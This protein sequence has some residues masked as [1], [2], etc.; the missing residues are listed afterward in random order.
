[1]QLESFENYLIQEFKN[2]N[3]AAVE[4]K[5]SHTEKNSFEKK[6]N[7]IINRHNILINIKFYDKNCKLLHSANIK[8]VNNTLAKVSEKKLTNISPVELN[9]KFMLARES[10]I[11]NICKEF[12]IKIDELAEKINSIKEYY[13]KNI[14]IDNSADSDAVSEDIKEKYD[15]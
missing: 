9:K 6:S 12:Q 8:F 4:F 7:K 11:K 10:I 15:M 3:Y 13:N 2:I 14:T 1:M 5:Y